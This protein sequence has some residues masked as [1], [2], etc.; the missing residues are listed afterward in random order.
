MTV[1]RVL[2]LCAVLVLSACN[3]G[4]EDRA[5]DQAP[6]TANTDQHP[7]QAQKVTLPTE[8]GADSL[9]P[10]EVSGDA[11]TVGTS[12][13]NGQAVKSTGSQFTVADT[14]YASASVRGKPGASVTAYW[15]YQ[16]GTSH[17][18]ETVQL[19]SGGAQPVAFSFKKGDG[20]V[21]GKYNV[22][23]DVDMVPVGIADFVIK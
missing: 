1:I 23:I 22:Q 17:K 8:P 20:M 16:D 13:A 14:V 5:G 10:V 11:V 2:A 12:L 18:E 9:L 3:E 19:K 7:Q 4:A 15:T 6:V 21:P